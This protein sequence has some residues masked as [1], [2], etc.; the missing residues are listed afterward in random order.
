MG[1]LPAAKE[2]PMAN[3][4]QQAESATGVKN[5]TYDVMTVLTN[6]LQSIATIEQYKQDAQG[7][8]EILECFNQIQERERADVDKL[9]NLVVQRLG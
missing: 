2:P 4:K 9:R 1:Y 8:S 7:D 6:K 5:T 3:N